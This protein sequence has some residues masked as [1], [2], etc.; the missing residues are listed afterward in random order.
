MFF[1]TIFVLFFFFKFI[2]AISH[3]NSETEIQGFSSDTLKRPFLWILVYFIAG[4][5]SAILEACR[6]TQ[7]S[8]FVKSQKHWPYWAG[9]VQVVWV[10]GWLLS[11][12][13]WLFGSTVACLGGCRWAAGCTQCTKSSLSAGWNIQMEKKLCWACV[14]LSD[15]YTGATYECS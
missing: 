15:L 13:G 5:Y 11:A 6:C 10:T 4:L 14:N 3:N 8:E 12:I 2:S 9:A 7:R 1:V